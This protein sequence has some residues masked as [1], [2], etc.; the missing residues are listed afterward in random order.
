[1][2]DIKMELKEKEHEGA[3]EIIF[4]SEFRANHGFL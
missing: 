4:A 1:V 2:D 3:D